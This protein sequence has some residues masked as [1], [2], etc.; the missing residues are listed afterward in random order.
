MKI[1]LGKSNIALRKCKGNDKNLN[2]EQLKQKGVID[3]LIRYN[4]GFKFLT[5]L[6]GSPPYFE[7]AK[8]YLFPMIR[9]LG[10]A[11]LFCSFSSAETQWMYLLRVLGQLVDHKEYTDDKLEN[12]NWK[13][14][15]RWIQSD[16]VMC[17]KHF[18]Y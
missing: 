7:E 13:D 12:V 11:A 6:R 3:R 2:A 8:K 16:P 15:C 10:P 14:R 17:A 1:L 18:D 9:Q 5:A 4:E